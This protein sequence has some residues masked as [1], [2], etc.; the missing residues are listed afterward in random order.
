MER[1]RSGRT[2]GAAATFCFLSIG[3]GPA[4]ADCPG[5]PTGSVY[6]YV[7][8]QTP[9]FGDGAA[10]SVVNG[11]VQVS[12]SGL[13]QI[14][15]TILNGASNAHQALLNGQ[16]GLTGTS[17]QMASTETESISNAYGTGTA[18]A[19]ASIGDIKDADYL[20]I[21]F[22]NGNPAVSQQRFSTNTVIPSLHVSASGSASSASGGLSVS[23]GGQVSFSDVLSISQGQLDEINYET[24]KSLTSETV[25]FDYHISGSLSAS[26]TDP[27]VAAFGSASADF[28]MYVT[29]PSGT[30]GNG[31]S[32]VLSAYE[33]TDDLGGENFWVAVTLTPDDPITLTVWFSALGSA[34]GQNGVTGSYNADY[35]HTAAFE[36]VS[37]FTD[38]TLTDR[39]PDLQL[40][41]ALGFDY[42][43]ADATFGVAAPEPSTW[44]MMLTGLGGLGLAGRRRRTAT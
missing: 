36:G 40:N 24:G 30:F 14:D 29:N 41:S 13:G 26:P 20:A 6:A 38:D 39:L 12:T 11:Q 16:F 9:F 43:P 32:D 34:K 8:S 15:T 4:L 44:A 28:E 22:A 37:F 35:S 10:I 23:S 27:H 31:G 17:G 25:E 3:A 2:R 42:I 33:K 18:S 7:C 1:G 19:S 5:V 21:P